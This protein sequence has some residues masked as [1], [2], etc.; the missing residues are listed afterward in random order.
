MNNVVAVVSLLMLLAALQATAADALELHVAPNGSDAWSGKLREPNA[1]H[2]DGPVASLTGA[3]DSLRKLRAGK[4]DAARIIVA[5]GTYLM[6]EPVVLAPEDGG[7][8]EA[9]VQYVAAAGARPIFSGG[10][11]I[12]GFE[13]G[14]DGLWVAKVPDVAA[15]KWYFEQ[16]FVNG[17][18]AVRAR[19]PNKFWFHLLDVQEEALVTSKDKRVVKGRRTIWLRPEDFACV[20]ALTPNE[21]KDVNLIV[22]HAWD[23]TRRFIERLDP[24]EHA[25]ITSGEGMSGN[26]WRKNSTLVLENFKAA[27]DAPGEWFLARDGTLFYKPLPGEDIAK[28]EVVAPVADKL[29][30]LK[31]DPVAGKFIEGLAFKGLSFLH[32]QWLTPPAGFEPMQAAAGIEAV[33]MGDGVRYVTFD[34]CEI[35]HVGT[36]ALWLRKGCQECAL[37]HC[38]IFDF[39]AGGVRIGEGESSK[40]ENETTHHIVVDN[41]IIRHGGYIFPCAVGVWIGASPD[42]Q[43]THNEIADMFYTGISAGWRWGY[44]ESLCKRNTISF[45]HVH[46]LGWGLLSDMGGIYTLGPSQGTVVANNIFHDIYAYSYGGWGMYTDEGSTG[47]VFEN[48]L[49]YNAKTGSFHQHYGKENII[50]NNILAFSKE[51]QLQAT[52]AE[53]HLSFTFEKNIIY[54]TTGPALCGPWDKLQFEARNNCYWNAA[55]AKV[56]FAGKSLEDWQKAGHEEGSIVADPL[57]ENPEKLDF[58]L[59]PDSPAL[60]LGFQP[61]DCTKAGVYGDEAWVA[62]AASVTYPPMEAPPEQEP[63]PINDTFE[64]ETVGQP[65]RGPEIHVE[66]KRDS[67]IVTD[68]TAATGKKSLK[69]TDAPGLANVWDPHIAWKLNYARGNVT[70]GFA[71]RVEKASIVD[72][73]WRDWGQPAYQVGARLGIR[74]GVL[75]LPGDA[76]L[77]LPLNE[78]VRFEITGGVGDLATG[79]WSLT[80][81]LPGQPAKEFKDLPYATPGFKRLTWAG[82]SSNATVATSYYLDDFSLKLK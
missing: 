16:L 9:P 35:G 62:K 69:I 2:T 81:Q 32:T 6:T 7:T 46:H 76:K 38:N 4:P 52:R 5:A 24:E 53:K 55:G 34:D 67:I 25:F 63:A 75:H 45:N 10:R 79:K 58:R 37:R 80:V 54:W 60:K 36:Y 31:G 27:L 39:G 41:N 8:R 71:L 43:V 21:L 77:E 48:N 11:A 17:H 44:A 78:W 30:V 23:N 18:R 61:F 15:G 33:I 20:G 22:Y 56:Q 47:I 82:F 65:P 70:N 49:V 1:D 40:K 57:F 51:H 72:F 28:A 12:T 66:G 29:L 14:A 73:E 13:T 26:P 59:K 50:R 3:R 74:E 19:T 42:N 64:R 68:E